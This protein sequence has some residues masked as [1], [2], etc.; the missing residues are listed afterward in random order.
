MPKTS[1][2]LIV[3]RRTRAS[4]VEVLLVHPGGPFWKNKD[5]G[6]WSIPKGEVADGEEPLAAARREFAEE[7]GTPAGDGPFVPLPPVKQKGG[8]TILAWAVGGDLDAAAVV[9]NTFTMEWPPRSGKRLT[10]PEVDRA[11]WFNLETAH[12]KLNQAQ[13]EWLQCLE[14]L[15]DA[16]TLAVPSVDSGQAG[17]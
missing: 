10:F 17:V 12:V 8:K 1:A 14:V 7:I 2:G 15:V 9:S 6:A 11:G 5:A 3:V 13:A 16:G 4:W